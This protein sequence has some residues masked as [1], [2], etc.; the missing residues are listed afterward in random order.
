MSKNDIAFISATIM[1]KDKFPNFN[2]DKSTQQEITNFK[3][4]FS[5]F[6]CFLH[7]VYDEETK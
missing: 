6:Y 5:T 2:P 1:I 3:E 7:K 4:T